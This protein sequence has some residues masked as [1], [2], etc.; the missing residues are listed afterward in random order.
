MIRP[1]T[2]IDAYEEAVIRLYGFWQLCRVK[3]ARLQ[4]KRLIFL[5]GVPKHVNLGDQAIAWAEI[6]FIKNFANAKPI[7]IPYAM[8]IQERKD[9][10]TNLIN[11]SDIIAYHGGGNMGDVYIY[12]E[13]CRRK[14]IQLFPKNDIVVFPET[15]HFTDTENGKK[16]LQKTQQIYAG[17][18][19]L[20][21]IA[22]E[23]PSYKKM[24][25]VFPTTDVILTPDIVL[26]MN[27]SDKHGKRDGLLL[28][29]RDDLESKLSSDDRK[30]ILDFE[31]DHFNTVRHTD[32]L[33]T[34]KLFSYL[35]KRAVVQAKLREF[36][37]AELVVTDRLHGMVFAA[38]TG[39]PCIA[40]SNF[41]HK[42]SNTYTWIENLSYV[43]FCESTS[44]LE[45]IFK[46]MPH[47]ETFSYSPAQFDEYWQEIK[48]KLA[49]NDQK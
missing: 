13:R 2:E 38:I 9:I 40:L 4:K 17:H 8:I 20:H 7:A 47:G 33:A 21:L 45:D 27:Q 46:S 32:T 37:S 31:R 24:T 29:L 43:R 42:V 14:C 6:D 49:A 44:G 23:K 18:S 10:L 25:E 35:P 1:L 19:K 41:N 36:K 22:R 39:T 5:L 26:S 16:E 48:A 28:C 12:E 15:I 11:P 30:A 3:L 34:T